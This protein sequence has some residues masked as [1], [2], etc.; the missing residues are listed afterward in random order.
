M[1]PVECVAR[2][3]LAGSGLLDYHRHRRGLR[4]PAAGRAAR[5]ASGC[6]S[7]SSP[8]PPR[9]PSASTTR[10][11]TTPPWSATVG[12]DVAA[13]TA[14]ADARRSTPGPRR[15]PATAA[16]SWPTPRSSSA[17]APTA[18]SCW[19]TRCSPP[20]RRASGRPPSGS[21][22]TRSRR[23]TSR[24]SA[25]GCS[26]RPPA[27]T[28]ASG[29]A[30]A[31]AARRGRGAHPGPLRRGLR[32]ADRRDLP[33]QVT[34]A[35]P[36]GFS[37][38]VDLPHAAQGGCS[39]TSSTRATD[40]S[41]RPRC[42]R[43]GSTSATPSRPSASPGSDTTVVGVKPRDGDHRAGA[44]PRLHRGGHWAGVDDAADPAVRR[45]PRKG[46]RI[47][48]EGRRRGQR[49]LRRRGRARRRAVVASRSIRADLERASRVLS[50]RGPR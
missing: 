10:T 9:P 5:T 22:A 12:D 7:R 49:R 34:A 30:P 6:P 3:Y 29:E 33:T 14:R 32:A 23:T 26:R 45:R 37:A 15:S 2:G 40:R 41:G 27:G 35:D 24:S 17:A 44:V 19:P 36:R 20:T 50:D 16:S 39:P 48:A 13:E 43:C 21:P 4:H 46:C 18:R 28:G 42:C 11:S 1:Y 38:T 31:A 25:T 8:R 47:H